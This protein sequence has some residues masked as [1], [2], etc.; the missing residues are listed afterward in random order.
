MR[1][2]TALSLHTTGLTRAG[3]LLAEWRHGP[4]THR[5][6]APTRS[7]D[8]GPAPGRVTVDRARVTTAG[9]GATAT[10]LPGVV[11]VPRRPALWPA[12]LLCLLFVRDGT[13][14]AATV[15]KCTGPTGKTTFSDQ[16]CVEGERAD[17]IDVR[18]QPLI[19]GPESALKSDADD[20]PAANSKAEVPAGEADGGQVAVDQEPVEDV[21]A[22]RLRRLDFLLSQLLST[23][24]RAGDDC[25]AATEGIRS[26]I[27]KHGQETRTLYADWD[28]IRFEKLALKKKELEAMRERLNRQVAQLKNQSLPRLNARCWN[29]RTLGAAFDDLQPYLPGS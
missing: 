11:R 18:G 3:G 25:T 24:N 10:R 21:R 4:A 15:Y 12:V 19:G 28:E 2:G 20:A 9:V 23:L 16:P 1:R 6:H 26:W 27:G 5:S 22:P 17:Q 7:T 29:D 14:Q 8:R 13:T